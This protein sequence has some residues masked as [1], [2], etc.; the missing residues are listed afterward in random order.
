MICD[1]E[2]LPL[3]VEVFDPEVN[4]EQKLRAATADDAGAIAQLKFEELL[5]GARAALAAPDS[6]VELAVHPPGQMI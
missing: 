6:D 5:A 1:R 3:S 2:G 4:L